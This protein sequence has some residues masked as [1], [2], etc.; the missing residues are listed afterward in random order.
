[1]RFSQ[2][3]ILFSEKYNKSD[4]SDTGHKKVDK[5]RSVF[6]NPYSFSFNNRVQA[7]VQGFDIK[8]VCA[9]YSFEYKNEKQISVDGK[10]YQVLSVDRKNDKTILTYGDKISL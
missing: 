3:A 2:K 8:G 7:S 9:I 5:G 10:I 1:M 6:V 4:I